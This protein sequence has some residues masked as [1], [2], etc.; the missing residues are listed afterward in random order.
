VLYA[1]GSEAL[2]ERIEPGDAERDPARARPRRVRLDE[3]RGVLVDLPENLVPGA[4][5]R[6]SPEEPRVPVDAGVEIRYRDT[7]VEGV[8]ALI[9]RLNLHRVAWCSR[10][11]RANAAHSSVVG[12]GAS[13]VLR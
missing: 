5:V 4:K 2:E 13:A 3:E 12:S 1:L 6:G 10:R 9:S 11:D 8:I 7:G